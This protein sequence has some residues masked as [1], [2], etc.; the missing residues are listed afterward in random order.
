MNGSPVFSG[1][2]IIGVALIKNEGNSF[3]FTAMSPGV[4]NVIEN[5]DNIELQDN[6]LL[7]RKKSCSQKKCSFSRC[8]MSFF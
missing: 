5:I 3:Q 7:K 8:G 1:E 4:K 2:Y 6:S